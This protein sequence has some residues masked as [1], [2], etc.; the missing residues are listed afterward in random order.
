MTMLKGEKDQ[1]KND[2]AALNHQDQS[3]RFKEQ[4]LNAHDSSSGDDLAGALTS[5][6]EKQKEQNMQTF[7]SLTVEQKQHERIDKDIAVSRQKLHEHA[8]F[9]ERLQMC[10]NEGPANR[11]LEDEQTAAQKAKASYLLQAKA[12][13]NESRELKEKEMELSSHE[14]M[15]AHKD[16]ALR[17]AMLEEQEKLSLLEQKEVTAN[18]QHSELEHAETEIQQRIQ[19][20]EQR[21]NAIV[22]KHKELH[23]LISGVKEQQFRFAEVRESHRETLASHAAAT[24]ETQSTCKACAQTTGCGWCSENEKCLVHNVNAKSDGL[25][26]GQCNLKTWMSRITDRVSALNF[27]V[28]GMDTTDSEQRS[29]AI[30]NVIIA[31]NY[32][33]FV[34]FQEVS[35]WYF[36]R[37]MGQTFVQNYYHVS[38]F[39]KPAKTPGGL[40]IMSRFNITKTNFIQMATSS[41]VSV[42]SRPKLLYIETEVNGRTITI[43]TTQLTWRTSAAASESRA[44]ALD[45]FADVTSS[46][47]NLIF[48][49]DF[50]FDDGSQPETGK[51]PIHW[52]DLWPRLHPKGS[53]KLPRGPNTFG[54][55]WDPNNNWYAHFADANSRP[56]RVDRTFI[57]SSYLLPQSTWLVGCPHPDYLCQSKSPKKPK[58]SK[59]MFPSS[60]FGLLSHF[61]VF[62]PHC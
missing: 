48:M 53:G 54:Y 31:A 33:D 36:D 1:N 14:E 37:L 41:D 7:R 18:G 34:A 61:S 3:M 11:R 8:V 24:C 46:V 22:S 58:V 28:F 44:T 10:L 2:I 23:G 49:G 13:E 29:N 52:I 17:R 21:E 39:N 59:Q 56:S 40:L 35:E 57:R 9:L 51:I 19:N 20:L 6:L 55:T 5:M 38:T 43:A 12:L 60:H 32:P 45:F 26:S 4:T 47:E 42:D 16:A 62:T 50:N 30:F 15:S 27:N 25:T